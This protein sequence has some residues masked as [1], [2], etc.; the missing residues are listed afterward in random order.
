M[1]RTMTMLELVDA[2][3]GQATTEAEVI[4]TIVHLVNSG[5][6]RLGGNFR[7]AHFDVATADTSSVLLA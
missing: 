2:V 6:I 1:T 3:S 4:A 7:G 5:M